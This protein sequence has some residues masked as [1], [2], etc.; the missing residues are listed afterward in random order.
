MATIAECAKHLNLSERRVIELLEAGVVERKDRGAYDFDVVR[1]SYIR[2]LRQRALGTRERSD[3]ELERA[4]D[5]ARLAKAK[6][7]KA[8]MEAQEMRLSLIPTA[9][10]HEVMPSIVA[11]V[12]DRVALIP[13]LAAK[14]AREARS[15]AAAEQIIRQEVNQA[16]DDIGA[17]EI[18]GGLAADKGAGLRP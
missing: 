9:Q 7:D 5:E 16:L 10:V 14:R 1:V 15:I 6:A 8:E 11:V 2:Y 18:V 13:K 12:K 4:Q 3:A 17:T